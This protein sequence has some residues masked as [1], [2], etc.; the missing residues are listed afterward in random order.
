MRTEYEY[1]VDVQLRFANVTP[2]E[3]AKLENYIRGGFE[4]KDWGLYDMSIKMV[5]GRVRIDAQKTRKGV[6]KEELLAAEKQKKA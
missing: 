4:D 1:N 6:T 3:F 2:E 5:D